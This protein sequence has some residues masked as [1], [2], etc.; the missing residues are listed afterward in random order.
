M[1]LKSGHQ[2]EAADVM[3]K[4]IE[5]FDSIEETWEW[6]IYSVTLGYDSPCW[7]IMDRAENP[8]ELNKLDM[9]LQKNHAEKFSEL[10]KE[11]QI[12]IR[13]ME[14]VTG[15]FLPKWSLNFEQE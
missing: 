8:L 4:Y 6:D 15:W 11:F 1:Y 5:Y 13:R 12:H 14:K 10:W 7:I 3:K 2:K 9:Q